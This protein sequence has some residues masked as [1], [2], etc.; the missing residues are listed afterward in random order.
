MREQLDEIWCEWY[1]LGFDLAKRNAVTDDVA[2]CMSCT[3]W[4]RNLGY[5]VSIEH[6]LRSATDRAIL[7]ELSQ[8]SRERQMLWRWR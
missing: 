3:V 4:R 6:H 7:N 8:L 2:Q 1:E 5:Q